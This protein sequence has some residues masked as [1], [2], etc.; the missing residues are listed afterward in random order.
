MFSKKFILTLL[1]S[2][3]VFGTSIDASNR[4]ELRTEL[5]P[6]PRASGPVLG[7]RPRIDTPSELPHAYRRRTD[8]M[9][10]HTP[11]DRFY[12]YQHPQRPVQ[13]EVAPFQTFPVR[14]PIPSIMNNDLPPPYQPNPQYATIYPEVI[15]QSYQLPAPKVYLRR[16]EQPIYIPN[17]QYQNQPS[18]HGFYSAQTGAFTQSA[19]HNQP[20]QPVTVQ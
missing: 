10:A 4:D 1:G 8:E 5:L 20:M 2:A 3:L 6:P 14:Q 12:G 18:F 17:E 15:K 16:R 13:R 19:F 9:P 11:M 7:K